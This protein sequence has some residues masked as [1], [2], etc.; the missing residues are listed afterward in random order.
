MIEAV[1]IE[2]RCVGVDDGEDNWVWGRN[3]LEVIE[4]SLADLCWCCNCGVNADA[5]LEIDYAVL[6]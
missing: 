3:A 2:E 4:D 5:R 1:A 6:I